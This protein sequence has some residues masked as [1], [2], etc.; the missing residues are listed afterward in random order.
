MFKKLGILALSAAVTLL[1]FQAP[2]NAAATDPVAGSV[3]G[4]YVGFTL[5]M[6][7][8]VPVSAG[9]TS[10]SLNKSWTPTASDIAT[11]GGKTIG[12]QA[13][14]TQPDGTPVVVSTSMGGAAT[15]ISASA[16]MSMISFTGGQGMPLQNMYPA[17]TLTMP[18]DVSAYTS[19]SLS[20]NINVMN[21]SGTSMLALPTGNWTVNVVVTVNN[22]PV[23]E[24]TTR[25][26]SWA[27]DT[28]SG[29][30]ESA[31]GTSGVAP[32][33]ATGVNASA[34]VCVDTTLIA[35][36]DVLTGSATRLMVSTLR[37]TAI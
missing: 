12:F 32:T 34:R 20:T 27:V 5:P 31:S 9:I 26:A 15:G 28:M 18:A 13:T 21:R 4:S 7:S 3:V 30:S 6:S 8:T 23:T 24:S 33:G 35:N 19:G 17:N 10:I 29:L 16:S 36:T 14:V 1:G 2:A 25:G 22:T 11:L 37:S